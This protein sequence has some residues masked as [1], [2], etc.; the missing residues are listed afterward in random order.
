MAAFAVLAVVCPGI[1]KLVASMN[2]E[3][4]VSNNSKPNC[5]VTGANVKLFKPTDPWMDKNAPYH[6]QTGP[7]A[8]L[9]RA[10]DS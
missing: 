6:Y 9:V 3:C 5:F 2:D 10:E 7:L 8:Q 4:Y 1:A